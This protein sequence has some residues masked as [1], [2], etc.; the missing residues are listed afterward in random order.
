ML[1]TPLEASQLFSMVRS[2][3]KLGGAIAEVGVYRGAS[4]RVIREADALRPLHLFDT[5]EGLPEPASSDR[6]FG[7]GRFRQGQFCCSVGDV[8][9]Y[10]GIATNMHFHKGLFPE[11]GRDVERERFSFVHSDVD[12][13]RSSRSVLEFF[14][15]KLL[16][17]GIILTHD[18]HTCSGPRKAF[19]EFFASL[20][21]PLVELPGNQAMIVKLGSASCNGPLQR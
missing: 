3:S 12:L 7:T 18:Y 14:Y 1:L 16:P 11:T 19:Q 13:Y 8:K 4:A 9:Q 21:E 10:L 17:G 2:T 20:P 6:E 5:F 15:P